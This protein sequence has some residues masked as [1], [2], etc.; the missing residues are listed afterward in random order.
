MIGG[1]ATGCTEATTDVF[2]EA[3]LFDPIRTAATGRRLNIA[4]DARYR[5]ERGL[6]PAFVADGLEIATR[7]M[8][9]LC[10][11]EASEV[12]RVIVKVNGRRGNS[13]YINDG[14]YGCLFE[15]AKI[16]GSLPYPV[17]R[18]NRKTNAC[19]ENFAFWGVSCDS[20]DYVPGPFALPADMGE[21]DYIEIGL[22]GAYGRVSASSFNGY[23]EYIFAEAKDNPF[24]TMYAQPRELIRVK[25]AIVA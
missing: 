9:E 5:F 7:L 13:L 24:P 23:G 22:T 10:G 21:G 11:G 2:I 14:T 1:E 3:A 16:Y 8:L 17:R 4:S 12:V 15:G 25:A 19:T 6:D 18:L 20:I